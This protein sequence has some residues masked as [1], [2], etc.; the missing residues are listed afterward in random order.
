MQS[1]VERETKFSTSAKLILIGMFI[2]NIGNGIYT[3]TIGKILYDKTGA[4]TAFGIVISAEYIINF[5]LQLF[6]GSFVDK[7][8]PKH[9]SVYADFIRGIV[10]C[11]TSTMLMLNGSTMWIF[12]SILVINIAKPFYRASTFAIGPAVC[13]GDLLARYNSL[14]SMFLQMG[15]LLGVALA[16]ILLKTIGNNFSLAVN[17]LSYILCGLAIFLAKIPFNANTE[18]KKYTIG[19]FINDWKEIKDVLY[20]DKSLAL[21]ILLAAGDF[22]AVNFVNLSL[23][24]IVN[25]KLQNNVYWLSVFDGSFAVG[26]IVA[27]SFTVL[28]L[29]KIGK[30]R[31]SILGGLLQGVLFIIMIFLNSGI[32]ILIF[33]FLLGAINTLS[34][35]VFM[36][37][38]QKKSK[39]NIKGRI[40]SIRQLNLSILASLILPVVSLGYKSGIYMG[41][42]LS[43]VVCIIFSLITFIL[44]A[45]KVL[46][47][48]D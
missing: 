30:K 1:I 9:V 36:T 46:K 10:L 26:A 42:F 24:P 31:V 8:N 41:L 38:I 19:V 2:T 29:D 5:L 34:L 6:A 25:V 35:T 17:G 28:I 12:I 20:L 21:F 13:N 23:V 16:G 32:L 22:I 3:L 48:D 47:Y 33:M 11:I 4:P 14:Y 45:K 44:N 7:N 39:G 18:E 15:Q 27:A 43:G 40:A 37:T